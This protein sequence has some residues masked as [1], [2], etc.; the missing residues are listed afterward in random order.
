MFIRL[1]RNADIPIRNQGLTDDQIAEAA[2]LYTSWKSLAQIGAHLGV[3]HTT[4][5]R[6]LIKR[7]VTMRDTHSRPT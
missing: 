2:Q 5:H 1:L 7:G 3:D 4:V 6:Q